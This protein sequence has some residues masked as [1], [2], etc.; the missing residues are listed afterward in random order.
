[1]SLKNYIIPSCKYR[2]SSLSWPLITGSQTATLHTG[3]GRQIHGELVTK[4]WGKYEERLKNK[5]FEILW[6]DTMRNKIFPHMYEK[7]GCGFFSP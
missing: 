1:M 6:K 4:N 7:V 3:K 2:I 5:I